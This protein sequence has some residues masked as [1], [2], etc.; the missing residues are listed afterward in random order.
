[1]L[2]WGKPFESEKMKVGSIRGGTLEKCYD[3]LV[4]FKEDPSK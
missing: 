4:T 3:F 1:M 2:K